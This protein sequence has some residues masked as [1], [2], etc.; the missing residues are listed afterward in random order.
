MRPMQWHSASVRSF[1]CPETTPSPRCLYTIKLR[2]RSAY[3][4]TGLGEQFEIGYMTEPVI[5]AYDVYRSMN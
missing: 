4:T 3:D 1:S 2:K 5:I